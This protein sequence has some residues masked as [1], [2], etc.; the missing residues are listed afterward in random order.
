[1]LWDHQLYQPGILIPDKLKD[2]IEYTVYLCDP[3][4]DTGVYRYTVITSSVGVYALTP[5]AIVRSDSLFSSAL[6]AAKSGRSFS[7]IDI[8][9]NK[10]ADFSTDFVIA[11]NIKTFCPHLDLIRAECSYLFI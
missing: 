7:S 5:L 1:M 10:L 2:G 11:H 8:N 6:S 4:P 9:N 3:E